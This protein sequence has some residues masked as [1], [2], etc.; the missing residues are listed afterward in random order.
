MDAMK[1]CH[2]LSRQRPR[3]RPTCWPDLSLQSREQLYVLNPRLRPLVSAAP[4]TTDKPSQ[5]LVT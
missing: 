3:E 2:L 5:N 4:K 1:S